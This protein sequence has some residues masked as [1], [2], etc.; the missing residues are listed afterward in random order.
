[1]VSSAET[2]G[3]RRHAFNYACSGFRHVANKVKNFK[4]P[5]P[6]KMF[7]VEKDCAESIPL[8]RKEIRIRNDKIDLIRNVIQSH[9]DLLAM[10]LEALKDF[11]PTP[12]L[13]LKKYEPIDLIKKQYY[14]EKRII[15]CDVTIGNYKRFLLYNPDIQKLFMKYLL[16][17][18]NYNGSPIDRYIC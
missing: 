1:M 2:S 17:S 15:N 11:R 13:T 5:R 12:L 10:S 3:C 8:L 18:P 6:P 16:N 4:L 7:D 9:P 14:L